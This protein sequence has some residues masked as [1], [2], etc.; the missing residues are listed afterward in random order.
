[1]KRKKIIRTVSPGSYDHKLLAL[2][3]ILTVIGL[4]A[5]ADASAPLALRNFDDKFYF[6]KQQIAAAFIGLISMV[7]MSKIHFGYWKKVGM[8]IFIGNVFLLLIVLIPG[9]GLKVLGARRWIDLGFTTLQ[10]SEFIKLTLAIYLATIASLNKKPI[11]YFVPIGLI[12]LLVMLQPDLGTT[13]II[14]LIA[15]SQ[16]FI[17]GVP[18]VYVAGGGGLGLIT[19]LILIVSSDYRRAR[20]MTFFEAS[21]DPL[22]SSY[23]IRQVLLALGSGGLFGLGVGHSKQKFLFLPETA[24]DSIFA[25]I[26]EE[27]GFVGATLLI[28]MFI[29]FV[30][31]ALS[32]A[33][34]APDTFSKLLAV[35]ITT[36]I[37]GQA[38]LNISAMVAIVPLTGIPLPFF[39]YGGSSLVTILTGVGILLNIS[40]YSEKKEIHAK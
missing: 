24:T 29:F 28:A 35:G 40:R 5:V 12:S 11:A 15:F 23:H 22:G 37:G 7:I 8:L 38:L 27:V 31:R 2:T 19:A 18:L 14:V 30:L 21:S 4:L 3:L 32:I 36:W 20:L 39:S 25:V 9:I 16:I 34:R 26:A 33:K 6:V 17:S 10:P 1:M 13:I